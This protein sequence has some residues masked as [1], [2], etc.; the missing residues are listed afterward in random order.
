[1]PR[2]AS[3]LSPLPTEN[4]GGLDCREH[5]E[6]MPAQKAELLTA[7]T[8]HERVNSVSSGKGGEEEGRGSKGKPLEAAAPWGPDKGVS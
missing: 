3:S 2:G 5:A 7:T 4:Q 1:M 8:P 6:G